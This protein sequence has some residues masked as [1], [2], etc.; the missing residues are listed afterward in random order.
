MLFFDLT[1]FM[2]YLLLT[3]IAQFQNNL[4]IELKLFKIYLYT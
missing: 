4:S 3:I 1:K 2:N